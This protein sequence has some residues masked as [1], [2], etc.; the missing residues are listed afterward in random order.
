MKVDF[1]AP[2]NDMEGKPVIE[3]TGIPD[4]IEALLKA[5]VARENVDT[6][7]TGLHRYFG[8]GTPEQR[9]LTAAGV[10]TAALQTVEPSA[11]GGERVD[12][13]RL[14]MKAI[15]P[16]QPAEITDKEK[17]T[18]LKAVE[19]AYASSALVYFRMHELL[20]PPKPQAVESKAA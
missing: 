1:N 13:M 17:E 8:G 19:K 16:A 6:A 3:R 9:K 20:T 12:R 4:I 5:G 11:S 14:V 10:A 15:D 7:L 18:L 2:I